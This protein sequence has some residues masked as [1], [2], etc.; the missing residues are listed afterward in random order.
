MED[1]IKF[2]DVVDLT[3]ENLAHTILQEFGKLDLDVINCRGLTFDEFSNMSE[4]FKGVQAHISQTQ[5]EAIYSHCVHH[6][7][8]LAISRD[9]FFRNAMGVI[10][11]SSIFFCDFAAIFQTMEEEMLERHARKP[12]NH[13]LKS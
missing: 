10:S 2:D 4:I 7:L 1:F 6:R 11:S 8:N 13:G 5:P 3:G 12:G 9:C